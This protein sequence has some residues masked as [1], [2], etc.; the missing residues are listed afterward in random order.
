ML[1]LNKAYILLSLPLTTVAIDSLPSGCELSR[2]VLLPEV[3]QR[4]RRDA[5]GRG[6]LQHH[7]V[8]HTTRVQTQG[9][10]LLSPDHCRH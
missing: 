10:D 5:G 6:R 9:H 8:G 4:A 2:R 1:W 7:P 3:Q